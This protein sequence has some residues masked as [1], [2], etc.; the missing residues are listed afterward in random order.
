[1]ALLDR[2]NDDGLTKVV[3]E[4]KSLLLAFGPTP[5]ILSLRI[6]TDRSKSTTPPPAQPHTRRARSRARLYSRRISRVH[7]RYALK[8]AIEESEVSL[9]VGLV[10]DRRRSA[11]PAHRHGAARAQGPRPR[12]VRRDLDLAEPAARLPDRARPGRRPDGRGHRRQPLP[13]LRRRHRGQLHR[14]LASRRSW[15]RSRSRPPS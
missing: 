4:G 8:P 13:R 6:T 12:R 7:I 14:P 11:R 15:P 9:V 10:A 3:D 5:P 1:M 2:A